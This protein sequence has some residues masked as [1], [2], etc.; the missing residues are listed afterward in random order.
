M[1][2]IRDAEI[3]NDIKNVSVLPQYESFKDMMREK[4]QIKVGIHEFMLW[5]NSHAY[6]MDRPFEEALTIKQG[7]KICGFCGEKEATTSM[8]AC[9]E[10]YEDVFDEANRI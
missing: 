5:I 4:Y 1:L 3:V 7:A 9:D 6:K 2:V 8:S 10:C